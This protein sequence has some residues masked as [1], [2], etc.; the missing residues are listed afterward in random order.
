[1]RR[2]QI[3]AEREAARQAS[4]AEAVP[5]KVEPRPCVPP[6][7]LST[8]IRPIPGGIDCPKCGRHMKKHGAHFHIRACKGHA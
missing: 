2:R 3:W 5:E 8:P 4:I 1:M 6:L 7:A